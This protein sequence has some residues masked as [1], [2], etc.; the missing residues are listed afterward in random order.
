MVPK[1]L[2]RFAHAINKFRMIATL[3]TNPCAIQHQS[4]ALSEIIH[5][6]TKFLKSNSSIKCLFYLRRVQSTY[7]RN[8]QF[9]FVKKLS[10]SA[11]GKKIQR[12]AIKAGNYQFHGVCYSSKYI[13][14][15]DFITKPHKWLCRLNSS[16][17]GI[18]NSMVEACA[19]SLSA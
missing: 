10:T 11:T 13:A 15:N 3:T 5:Y 6:R 2:Q 19:V 4:P 7:E 1:Q 9:S 12:N 8:Y 18:I 14:L 16:Y 17:T